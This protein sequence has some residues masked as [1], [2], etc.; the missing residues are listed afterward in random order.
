MADDLARAAANPDTENSFAGSS[1]GLEELR[2]YLANCRTGEDDCPTYP[3]VR[4]PLLVVVLLQKENDERKETDFERLKCDKR[5]GR[6]DRVEYA[7]VNY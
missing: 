3:M 5:I 6:L 4:S 7:T 2:V 1:I